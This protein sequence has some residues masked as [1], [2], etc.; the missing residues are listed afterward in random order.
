MTTN[1]VKLINSVCKN[2]DI[3][4]V[5]APHV[6]DLFVGYK[7]VWESLKSYHARFKSVP[8]ISV[9]QE[10]HTDL[11]TADVNGDSRY[12]LDSLKKEYLRNRMERIAELTGQALQSEAPERVLEK[13]QKEYAKLNRFTN[14]V[15]DFE[16][17]DVDRAIKHIEQVRERSEVMGGSPGIP[18]GIDF[19]DSAYVTGMAPGHLIV[20]IG[21]PGKGKQEWVENVIPTP[22]GPRRFGDLQRGDLVFGSDGKPTTVTGVFP[23]ESRK[24]M[25]VTFT[26]NTS[27]IVGPDHLWNIYCGSRGAFPENQITMTTQEIL[28]RGLVRNRAG[29]TEYRALLPLPRP[30][31]Y[32]KVDLPLDPYTLGAMI[33]DGSYGDDNSIAMLTGNDEYIAERIQRANPDLIVKEYPSTTCRRW[34]ILKLQ[35]RFKENGWTAVRHNKRIPDEYMTA[36]YE[37][38]LELL[39]GLMDTDGHAGKRATFSQ[40]NIVIAEQVAELVRSLGGVASVRETNR[41]GQFV[42]TLWTP[43]NPFSL[44][45]KAENYDSR[46]WR[47]AFKS[48]EP[49]EDREMQCI[50]VE[51]TD[52]LYLTEHYTVT[53]NTWLSSYIACNAFDKGYKPMMFSLEMSGENMA[54]RIYTIMG[55]GLF[56][57]SGFAR[58]DVNMDDFR[59]FGKRKLTERKG[60]SI[61]SP[62][63]LNEVTPNVIQGKFE[64]HHPD[65]IICD[66]A[67]LFM[68]NG[69]SI[70]MTDRMRNLSRELKSFAVSNNVPVILITAATQDESSD[71]DTP[72]TLNKVAWSKSIEYD[73]DAAFA[74]QYNEDSGLF[75]VVGRKNRHGTLFAGFLEWDI[76]RGVVKERFDL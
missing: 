50:S 68:D 43:D 57:N 29:H 67:Q 69:R 40:S 73:A 59:E 58:G 39:R 4:V 15:Q 72:P 11:E 30:V 36:H 22:T 6:D 51:A 31:E 18:T 47:K 56:T 63:G 32:D 20:N 35:R 10:R 1:E 26:D 48:I 9:L 24:A 2:K 5:L 41:K 53:H 64:Q 16:I 60:F 71:T 70:N 14:S 76:N 27:V 54:E 8:D 25:K 65:L 38:R 75:E 34:G 52:Q 45:R 66:Y 28:D 13:V 42:V 49:V 12:Y 7:D 61:V 55:N 37:A 44:P 21:W 74:T 33:G 19:I 62:N 3:A 23:Q 46:P 17:T